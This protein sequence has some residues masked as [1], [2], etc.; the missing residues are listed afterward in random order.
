V[1]LGAEAAKRLASVP[2]H[3]SRRRVSRGVQKGPERPD[4]VLR[5]GPDMG[6]D[7]GRPRSW[8]DRGLH[9]R[10]RPLW[11]WPPGSSDPNPEATPWGSVAV[12]TE[13]SLTRI[14]ARL[15]GLGH[16]TMVPGP[17]LN[18][19]VR[20]HTGHRGS[21]CAQTR[22]R[23][24]TQARSEKSADVLPHPRPARDDAGGGARTNPEEMRRLQ[25]LRPRSR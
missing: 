1:L 15:G 24:G 5:M 2:R 11:G 17:A 13:W 25:G 19:A 21:S 14:V 7:M 16:E 10:G 20:G 3:G 23:H 6:L 4:R 12:W 22:V 8:G 18:T 9:R